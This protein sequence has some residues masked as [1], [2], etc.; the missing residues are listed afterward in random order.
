VETVLVKY[1]QH[2]TVIHV[3][4]LVVLQETIVKHVNMQDLFFRFDY[5]LFEAI[6]I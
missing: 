3:L 5:A 2:L 4:V 6:F 1:A